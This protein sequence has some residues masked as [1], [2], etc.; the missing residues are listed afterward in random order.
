MNIKGFWHICMINDWQS[1]IKEQLTLMIRSGLYDRSLIIYIGCTGGEEQLHELKKIIHPYDKLQIKITSQN[2]CDYEFKTIRYIWDRCLKDNAFYGFYIH[3]KGVSY[4]GHEGG[5]Y[6]RDYMNYYII[7]RWKDNLNKLN[8]GYDTC[9]VKLLMPAQSP[10]RKLHYSG[11]FWWFKSIYAK[12]LPDPLLLNTKDRFSAEMWI[13]LADP[14]ACSLCQMFVDYNTKGKF[15]IPTNMPKIFIHTLGYNLPGEIEK[16]TKLIYDQ[17]DAGHFKHLICDLGFPIE[18]GDVIP[19]NYTLARQKNTV[20]L[21]DI[22]AKY[23]STYIR[24]ENIGVSQNW[25]QVIKHCKLADDDV[26]IGADPDERTI[27]NGWAMAMAKVLR[28][29]KVGM[30]SLI[31]P[32]QIKMM[33]G[34]K[35]TEY[36]AGDIRAIEVHGSANWALIGFKGEFLKKMGDMPYPE[37]HPKYGYIETFVRRELDKYGYKCLF[38][39]DYKVYHTDWPKDEG[40]PKLLREWKN[41]IIHRVKEYG[42]LDFTKYLDMKKRG[43]IA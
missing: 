28:S 12:I 17:N 10:S 27:D 6:W 29:G 39:P 35:Y 33:S 42:Q 15:Q 30:V 1:I 21:K 20:K 26:I 11:N 19:D 41:Q 34:W 32:E 40:S 18:K 23:G 36:Q 8:N 43:Q 22:C 2:I 38:L 37:D 24:L 16:T 3:T 13:G 5:K 7:S 31:M 14:K 25:T 9:G 4:P